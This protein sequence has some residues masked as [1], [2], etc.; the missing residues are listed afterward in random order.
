[1]STACFREV[2]GSLTPRLDDAYQPPTTHQP[3]YGE[4]F[5]GDPS[6]IDP[7]PLIGRAKQAHASIRKSGGSHIVVVKGPPHSGKKTLLRYFLSELPDR[8]LVLSDGS[9]LPVLALALDDQSITD[10]V[11]R[12]YKFY[13][14]A[15]GTHWDQPRLFDA[16]DPQI[17]LDRISELA[18]TYPAC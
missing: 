3:F 7:N 6:A 14:A 10:L 2:F 5:R 8:H 9:R 12:A 11:H 13:A 18:K 15:T 1:D 16:A 17:K 4:S